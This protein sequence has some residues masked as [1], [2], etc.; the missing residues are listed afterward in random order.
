MCS[1]Q[2]LQ[3]LTHVILDHGMMLI[4]LATTTSVFKLLLYM[5]VHSPTA[6][7]IYVEVYSHLVLVCGVLHFLCQV[8]IAR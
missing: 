2:E 6:P 3:Q 7:G 8:R 5:T 1:L 4:L